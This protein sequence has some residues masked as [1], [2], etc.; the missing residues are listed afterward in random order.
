MA[1]EYKNALVDITSTGSYQTVYTC[2][3]TTTLQKFTAIV[4]TFT[5]QNNAGSASTIDVQMTDNSASVSKRIHHDDSSDF[6]TDETIDAAPMGPLV[7][8]SQDSLA[9]QISNQPCT[10]FISV[11]EISEDLKGL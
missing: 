3:T 6:H 8:E 1:I 10:V 4:K 5:V 2:P 11:M 9:V 7:L